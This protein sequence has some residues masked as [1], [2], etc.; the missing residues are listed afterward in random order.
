LAA[1]PTSRRRVVLAALAGLL[2][3]CAASGGGA[4]WYALRCDRA[5]Y[6]KR[7]TASWIYPNEEYLYACGSIWHS[8]DKGQ[9]WTQI[10]AV[11]L[12]LLVREGLIAV[13]RSPG[14]LYLG[15]LESVPSN[16]QCLLCPL[17]RVQPVMFLSEDG[18][19]NWH[20]AQ[21]LP[22]DL[23]GITNFRTLN[24]NPD[25]ANAGWFELV[26]GERVDYWGSNDGGHKWFLTCEE[27][28]GYFCDPPA[29]FMAASQKHHG[30]AP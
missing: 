22:E 8:L 9:T 7:A 5:D 3:V 19:R 20:E 13:D 12:P 11:G 21:R 14:R 28:M 30:A 10:P 18:G 27:R 26:S 23:A 16:L 25:Y 4:A 15:L 6:L 24:A 17:T 29:D 2:F 1:A